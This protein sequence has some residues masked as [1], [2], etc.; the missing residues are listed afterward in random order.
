MIYHIHTP[1]PLFSGERAGVTFAAGF[2]V[3]S[4][5]LVAA[6]LARLGY[7][8]IS[9]PD[10]FDDPPAAAPDPAPTPAA[11]EPEPSAKRRNKK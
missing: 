3:T 1:N 9:Q 5:D 11:E 6:E 4:D 7:T 10:P 2:G 8:V